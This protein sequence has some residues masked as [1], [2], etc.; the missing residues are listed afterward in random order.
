MDQ[1]I[2]HTSDGAKAHTGNVQPESPCNSAGGG[3]ECIGREIS[4]T[5]VRKLPEEFTCHWKNRA[6]KQFS[7]MTLNNLVLRCLSETSGL[8]SGKSTGIFHLCFTSNFY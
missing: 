1:D 3:S 4:D 6:R 7:V 2:S 8:F 5:F